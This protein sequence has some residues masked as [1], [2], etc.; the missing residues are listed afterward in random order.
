MF[1]ARTVATLPILAGI[2]STL[3]LG[4]QAYATYG[5]WGTPAVDFYINPAN[6]DVTPAAAQAALIAG[7]SA[8][9]AQS[10]AG[11]R[12]VAAG[13]ANDTA[14]ANDGRNVVFFRNATNGSAIAST[15]SWSN[16]G[17]I[18][19]ADIIFWDGGFTFFTGTSGCGGSNAAYIEDIA[20]HEFGHALGLNH[21][22]VSGATMYPGY[23]TCSMAKRSIEADDVAGVEALYPP[24]STGTS[25]AP[26]V[27]ISNPSSGATVAEGTSL[28]FSG[29]A[30]DIEDGALN[31]SL[32]WISSR[33]GQIG[34]GASFQRVLS[35]GT[36]TITAKVTDSA[37][38][39]SQAQR[40][41]TVEA[42]VSAAVEGLAL[43]AAGYKVNGTAKVDLRWSGSTASTIDVWRNGVRIAI[44]PNDGTY[45]DSLPLQKKPIYNYSYKVCVATTTTCSVKYTVKF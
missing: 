33:D 35:T 4:V 17:R 24:T 15:Y 16:N 14:T 9:T 31:P 7:A 20:T 38:L 11:F 28:S 19:D 43:T 27:T 1:R 44:T 41:L 21:S 29:S 8:W 26:T 45:T 42:R 32:I 40:N 30:S 6:A 2:I 12:F 25:T 3:G 22:T 39:T 23:S 36:H 10:D 5:K 37:G 34:S 13:T 18:V